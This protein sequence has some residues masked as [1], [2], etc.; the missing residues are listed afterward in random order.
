MQFDWLSSLEI[1]GRYFNYFL[2]PGQLEFPFPKSGNVEKFVCNNFFFS[3][4]QKH[5]F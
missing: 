5:L 2:V 3:S 4:N 1:N